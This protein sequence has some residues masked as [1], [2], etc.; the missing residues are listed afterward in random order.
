M[1]RVECGK[2]ESTRCV[3]RTTT[4]TEY[5]SKTGE[6]LPVK[7]GEIIPSECFLPTPEGSRYA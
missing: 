1:I 6:W 5:L 2:S 4:T 7:D 3:V